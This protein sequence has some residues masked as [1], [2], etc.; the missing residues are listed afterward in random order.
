MAGEFRP[1]DLRDALHGAGTDIWDWDLAT[2]A[3]SASDRGFERLGYPAGSCAQTQSAWNT[4]IHPDDSDRYHRS[5]ERY[6]RGE[7]PLWECVYRIRAH[8]GRWRHYEERGRIVDWTA[9]GQP[10]RMLGTQTDVSERERLREEADRSARELE[11]L[12]QEAPGVLFRFRRDAN[13]WGWFPYLSARCEPVLGLSVQALQP[14]AAQVL[15]RMAPEDREA[16]LD[17]IA[18]SART[19]RPWRLRFTMRRGQAQVLIAGTASPR[20][21]ADGATLWHGYLEDVTELAALERAEHDK[22]AAEAANRAKSGF[23]ARI[24][25]ELRTPLNAVLGFT[26]LLETDPGEPLS[27]RQRQRLRLV[28]ESGQ[29]LLHLINDLLDLTRAES[30]QMALN[31]TTLALAPLA[32]ECAAMLAPTALGAAVGLS[33]Q[34]E[35]LL[36]VH[37]DAARLRQILLNLLDNAVKYNRRGG[38]VRLQAQADKLAV[39]ISVHDSGC[40][41]SAEE[42]PF[43]FD[44]FWRS[45]ATRGA[46][47]GSGIGLAVT[48]ALVRAMGGRIEAESRPGEG[49]VFRLTLARVRAPA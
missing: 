45:P 18:D 40:G 6:C 14:D 49:S 28:H 23:L 19:L 8:D 35:P 47:E 2:D 3:L 43:L 20:R 26:Q 5:F 24:S 36:W 4:L 16:M 37:A 44:P 13:G 38:W 31:A 12:A 29:H 39:H 9:D 27:E 32:E 33:V 1:Q 21:E 22:R 10:R 42:L 11:A 25:H 15:R 48:Q 7:T 46:L 41:I 34:V 30:G 17:S